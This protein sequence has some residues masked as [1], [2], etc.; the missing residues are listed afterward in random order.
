MRHISRTMERGEQH[1]CGE[2][3]EGTSERAGH[4]WKQ[5]PSKHRLLKNGAEKQTQDQEVG[6]RNSR[7]NLMAEV[8]KERDRE[9]GRYTGKR[10]ESGV[11]DIGGHPSQRRNHRPAMTPL[12]NQVQRDAQENDD[13]ALQP[14]A[15]SYQLGW[16]QEM[17]A[18]AETNDSS[19]EHEDEEEDS[20][21]FVAPIR[22]HRW[23]SVISAG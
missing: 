8:G 18:H 9:S 22:L 12:E 5:A 10:C 6:C 21:V 4:N 23:A 11:E 2:D 20:N 19:Q 13:E 3:R 16:A 7:H 14:Q 17:R 15:R 1:S